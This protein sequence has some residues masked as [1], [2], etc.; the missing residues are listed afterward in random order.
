MTGFL[1]LLIPFIFA[2]TLDQE[3][4]RLTDEARLKSGPFLR[5]VVF[6]LVNSAIE[7]AKKGLSVDFIRFDTIPC[8][9]EWLNETDGQFIQNFTERLVARWKMSHSVD[10]EII[11]WESVKLS[12]KAEEKY[13]NCVK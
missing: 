7:E 3:L 12:W 13:W 6:F 1:M 10:I 8:M 4:T 5:D 9:K 2:E 11:P